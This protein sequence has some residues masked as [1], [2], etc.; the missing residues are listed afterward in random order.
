MQYRALTPIKQLSG[1]V[2]IGEFIDLNETDAAE[3]LALNAIEP[4]DQ[5]FSEQNNE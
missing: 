4:V 3:L 5:P 2:Q 1:I